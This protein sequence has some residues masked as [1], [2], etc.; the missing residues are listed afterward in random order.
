M[1]TI[2][3][4]HIMDAA[5]QAEKI[6][7][8]EEQNAHLQ[9]QLGYFNNYK[10]TVEKCVE[11]LAETQ[12]GFDSHHIGERKFGGIADL[13]NLCLEYRYMR[14]YDEGGFIHET[15]HSYWQNEI[16]TECEKIYG[17]ELNWN[18]FD[19]E[20]FEK[21]INWLY[22]KGV[23]LE[24]AYE[25]CVKFMIAEDEDFINWEDYKSKVDCSD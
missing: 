1:T 10:T 13:E 16:V 7:F 12:T 3:L 6:K 15:G 22:D 5:N 14:S 21:F 24:G 20:G 2:S 25:Y 8:L 9:E 23:G 18:E 11:I 4:S 19:F 17:E